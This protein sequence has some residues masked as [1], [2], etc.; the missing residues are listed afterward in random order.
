MYIFI[1][2]DG[3]LRGICRNFWD[4]N[5]IFGVKKCYLYYKVMY[6]VFEICNLSIWVNKVVE[7][8][9]IYCCIVRNIIKSCKLFIFWFWVNCF[10]SKIV[11]FCFFLDFKI[12]IKLIFLLVI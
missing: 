10:V 9:L 3:I 12:S 11:V 5:I 1:V 8:K 2:Y 4:R 7:N 6:L